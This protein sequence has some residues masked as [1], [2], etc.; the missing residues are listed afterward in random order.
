M[1]TCTCEVKSKLKEHRGRSRHRREQHV[2]DMETTE[3]REVRYF[4]Y[5]WEA[6][7]CTDAGAEDGKIKRVG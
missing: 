2:Q 3:H 7:M 4:L 1:Q 5:R 6:E